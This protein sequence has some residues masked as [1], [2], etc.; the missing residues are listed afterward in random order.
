M[1]GSLYL[2]G[3]EVHAILLKDALFSFQEFLTYFWTAM[4]TS[5]T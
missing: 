4:I 3:K 5:R 2:R 1:N